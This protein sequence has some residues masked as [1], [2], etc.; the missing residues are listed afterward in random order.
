MES[1]LHR[2][3]KERF[4]PDCGGRA[5]VR[6]GQYRVDAVDNLGRLVEVQA[7]PLGV[8]KGKLARL[9]IEHEIR[10]IKPV[11]LSRRIVR[12]DRAD[13]PDKSARRSP[14]R[15]DLL[16]VFDELVGLARVFPHD[17]LTIEVVGVSIDE[18]RI[19]RRRGWRV[20]DRRLV[21]VVSTTTLR[22]AD[23]LWSL[24]PDGFDEPF[25][26][27]DCARTLGRP[28]AFAQRLAYCLRHAGAVEER[29]FFNRRRVYERLPAPLQPA[30]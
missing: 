6:V 20:A 14:K 9:L 11:V 1:T 2:Q 30:P 3:L 18:I 22:S 24:L 23:D 26:T 13:G 4:G 8:L 16:D 21:E 5:E 29:G 28:L 7:G 19:E 17:K 27:L 25:T 10:V 15:G 12:R